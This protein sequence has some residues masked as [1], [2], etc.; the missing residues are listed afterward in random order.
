MPEASAPT[1]LIM[2]LVVETTLAGAHEVANSVTSRGSS[3]GSSIADS[4]FSGVTSAGSVP[5]L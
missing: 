5:S 3:P 4:Q 2:S 1:N